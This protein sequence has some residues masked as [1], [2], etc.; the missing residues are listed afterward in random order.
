MLLWH[1]TSASF[2]D[3]SV[4]EWYRYAS[5]YFYTLF[6]L[7]M[8]IIWINWTVYDSQSNVNSK[9]F[10]I[11]ST[12]W[13]GPNVVETVLLQFILLPWL[14]MQQLYCKS[15]FGL[16]SLI[17]DLVFIYLLIFFFFIFFFDMTW[18]DLDWLEPN[19]Q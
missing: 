11:Y 14:Q 15:I 12:W 4:S 2:M 10:W 17:G 5:K 19:W 1:K 16:L 7:K 13:N 9:I 8:I 18:L 3:D 6:K